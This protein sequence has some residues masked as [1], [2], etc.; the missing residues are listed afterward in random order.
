[1]AATVIASY[2]LRFVFVTIHVENKKNVRNDIRKR[3]R[4]TIA[5]EQERTPK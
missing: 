5:I 3:T 2:L 1:M 4:H